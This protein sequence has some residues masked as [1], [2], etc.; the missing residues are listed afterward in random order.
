MFI[1]CFKTCLHNFWLHVSIMFEDMCTSNFKMCLYC[2]LCYFFVKMI[3]CKRYNKNAK[4]AKNTKIQKKCKQPLS[5][6]G[7]W[8]TKIDRL[9]KITNKKNKTASS[10]SNSSLS[11]GLNTILTLILIK[12]KIVYL[13]FPLPPPNNNR[14]TTWYNWSIHFIFMK[15]LGED[16]SSLIWFPLYSIHLA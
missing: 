6:K 9:K 16:S 8:K 14:T 4:Y 2:I 10:V 13:H 12:S 11:F 7:K 1:Q 5:Q 15:K 3:E